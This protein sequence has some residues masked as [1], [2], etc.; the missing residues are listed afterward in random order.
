ML[1]SAGWRTTGMHV[2]HRAFHVATRHVGP[3]FEGPFDGGINRG[4][5]LGARRLQHEVDDLLLRVLRI[6][7]MAYSDA[8]A[9]EVR[10]AE[11]GMDV[12]QSVMARVATAELQLHVAR[13]EIELVM[14]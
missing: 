1:A 7:R 6:A 11:C 10:S 8:Q 3:R 4:S 13:L 9:P 12:P 5:L 2:Q 14:H